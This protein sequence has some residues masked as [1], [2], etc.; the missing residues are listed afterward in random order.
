MEKTVF[1]STIY[2]IPIEKF[3]TDM[4]SELSKNK[5]EK[6]LDLFRNHN[7]LKSEDE[8]KRTECWLHNVCEAGDH[9]LIKILLSETIEDDS[10]NYLFK[11]DKTNKTASFYGFKHK[12]SDFVIPRTVK[13]KND[14]YLIP[15]ISDLHWSLIYTIDSLNVKFEEDSAVSTFHRY[16]LSHSNIEEI[17]FP[18]SLIELKDGWCDSTPKLRRIIISPTNGQ[19]IFKEEK[20]LIGKSNQNDNEFD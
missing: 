16:A 1:D 5:K 6:I 20:Y 7:E 3:E 11:I 15:S 17:Y 10:K 14:D 13:Y 19:F 2:E 18:E 9:E 12:L 4:N 8:Y